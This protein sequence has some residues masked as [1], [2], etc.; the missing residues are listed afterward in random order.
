MRIYQYGLDEDERLGRTLPSVEDA[1]SGKSSLV[2]FHPYEKDL[3]SVAA[4]LLRMNVG[5]KRKVLIVSGAQMAGLGKTAVGS[6][7]TQYGSDVHVFSGQ[8]F[9]SNNS[10]E[11]Q[12]FLKAFDR[13]FDNVVESGEVDWSIVESC[14]PK[15]VDEV[16]NRVVVYLFARSVSQLSEQGRI[17]DVATVLQA[18]ETIRDR[19]YEDA[20]TE[21]PNVSLELPAE[22]LTEENAGKI[23]AEI[24]KF[25]C[26]SCQA[27]SRASFLRHQWLGNEFDSI[28]YLIASPETCEKYLQESDQVRQAAATLVDD[29]D[30]SR[31]VDLD[32]LS[33]VADDVRELLRSCIKEVHSESGFEVASRDILAN[34]EEFQRCLR[35]CVET[36][37]D[38]GLVRDD[39]LAAKDC[40]HQLCTELERIPLGIFL[41]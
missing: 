36:A 11:G 15:E 37:D 25:T 35:V 32:V 19:V 21:L 30:P 34:C 39:F 29:F 17:G 38:E 41:Q 20:R 1:P 40:G 14:C 6:L 28:S 12:R 24:S 2:V 31:L 3:D 26:I 27:A 5:A 33:D 4:E 13:F 18:F 22:G 7:K 9:E 16:K 10:S 8:L 23:S